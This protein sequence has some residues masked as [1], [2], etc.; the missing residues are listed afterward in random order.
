MEIQ[1][2]MK[3]NGT[4][5][6]LVLLLLFGLAA[7]ISAEN[8][9]EKITVNTG[10]DLYSRYVWRGID[11]A[12]TPSIQ[13]AISVGYAG[14]ELGVWG[15]YT[16]SNQTSASDEIDFWLG[17]S[18]TLN[19]GVAIS[20]IVTDYTYPNSGSDFFN[21]NNYDAL[22]ADS[23][24]APGA[25]TLE[26]GASVTGPKTFPV[27]ISGYVNVYNDAGSNTY[28]QIDCPVTANETSLNFFCGATGG[29][30]DNP[31]YYGADNFSVIN[32]G[33]TASREIKMSAS[34][35]LPLTVQFILNPKAEISHLVVAL[36]F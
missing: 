27:T 19:N 5:L 6:P 8:T 35:A 36:S 2:K 18:R 15:A 10:V 16:L 20:G 11:I 32:L 1:V 17:Y 22:T 23:T 30:E 21:F 7:G 34:F 28:F 9:S 24:P 13:P 29:S 31:G 33:V 26:L 12:N 4:G 3:K 25:H 14:L